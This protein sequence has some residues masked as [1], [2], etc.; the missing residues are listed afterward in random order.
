[1]SKETQ[2]EH[3]KRLVGKQQ[4]KKQ[5]SKMELQMVSSITSSKRI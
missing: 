3:E 1:M 2:R 4:V 5:I